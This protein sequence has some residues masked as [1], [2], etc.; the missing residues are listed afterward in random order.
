MIPKNSV[1]YNVRGED[2]REGKR[3]KRWRGMGKWGG[4]ERE[5]CFPFPLLIFPRSPSLSGGERG[6]GGGQKKDREEGEGEGKKERE[7]GEGA[8]E[9]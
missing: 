6:G 9:L 7:E 3:M 8:E 2:M 5:R 1:F 4:R